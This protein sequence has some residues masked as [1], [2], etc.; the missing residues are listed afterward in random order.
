[1]TD[2]GFALAWESNPGSNYQILES[3]DLITWR[4]AETIPGNP[5]VAVTQRTLAMDGSLAKFWKI[6][7]P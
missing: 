7:R 3:A 2:E 6:V 1:V 4:L 5:T